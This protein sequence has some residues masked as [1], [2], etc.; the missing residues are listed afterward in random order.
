MTHLSAG[1]RTIIYIIYLITWVLTAHRS[2]NYIGRN[3]IYQVFCFFSAMCREWGWLLSNKCIKHLSVVEHSVCCPLCSEWFQMTAALLL[4]LQTC[5][6]FQS[7]H[8]IIQICHS[9][10]LTDRPLQIPSG[11]QKLMDKSKILSKYL[12]KWHQ[13]KRLPH[14][15]QFRS[16]LVF[17]FFFLKWL[18][19]NAE[20]F[21]AIP[22]ILARNSGKCNPT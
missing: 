22:K 12:G 6:I 18:D 2:S 14:Y 16:V 11:L 8:I 17:W 19:P 9:L 3:V 15:F 13:A 10:Y 4:Q 1:S 20:S 5:N 7:N 21:P